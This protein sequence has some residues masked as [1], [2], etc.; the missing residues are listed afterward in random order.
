MAIESENCHSDLSPPHPAL[1]PSACRG[2]VSFPARAEQ[3]GQDGEGR[4]ERSHGQANRAPAAGRRTPRF[5]HRA[6]RTHSPCV[7]PDIGTPWGAQ[8]GPAPRHPPGTTAALGPQQPPLSTGAAPQL[9]EPG[10]APTA[11]PRTR[12][13]GRPAPAALSAGPDTSSHRLCLENRPD[14][15]LPSNG[16]FRP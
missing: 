2:Q 10:M 3:A 7:Q 6:L 12:A 4:D 5:L 16:G 13:V 8:H 9:H 11:A 1:L 14:G 15:F